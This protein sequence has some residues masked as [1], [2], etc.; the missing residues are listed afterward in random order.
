MF[1]EWNSRA[2]DQHYVEFD[3]PARTSWEINPEKSIIS[4][5]LVPIEKIVLPPLHVKLG[6][7]RS[8]VVK[9]RQEVKD[10]LHNTIFE[11]K[12]SASKVNSGTNELFSMLLHIHSSFNS[13]N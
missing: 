9:L 4:P 7:I 1:C 2:Y 11:K 13:I 8:F 3:W 6:L 10:F 12:I 5:R